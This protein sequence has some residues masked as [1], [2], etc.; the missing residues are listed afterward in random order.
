MFLIEFFSNENCL[1]GETRMM[2]ICKGNF[3]HSLMES[4]IEQIL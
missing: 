2:Y 3:S 1:F 4:D